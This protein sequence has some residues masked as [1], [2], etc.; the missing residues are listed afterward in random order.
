MRFIADLHIHSHYSRATSKHM[1]IVE[2]TKWS[3]MKGTNVLGTGD[4]THPRWFEEIQKKLVEADDAPGLFRL[5]PE[6]ESEIQKEVPESCRVPMRFMLTVEISTIYKKNDA[7]R[8]VHSCIFAP[9]FKAAAGLNKTLDAIGNIKSDGRPILGLDTKLL[10]QHALDNGCFFVPA[11]IWTPHFSVFGS[12]SGFDTLQECFEDLTPHI[13]AIETGLSSDP[14]MNWRIKELDGLAIISNSDAHSAAKLGREAN[15]FNTD[16]SYDAII[17]ALKDNDHDAFEST[18]EFYPE[19]GKYHLDGH[20]NCGVQWMPSETLKNSKL[21]STCGKKVTVGVMH[22]VQDL[23]DPERGEDY[24]PEKFRPYSSIIPLPEIIAEVEGVKTLSSKK[25]QTKHLDMLTKLG[26]EFHI[27]LDASLSD[28]QDKAGV[29]MA[30]A[31]K[32]MREGTIHID[33]GY[34]GE[35]GHIKIFEPDEKSKLANQESLF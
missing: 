3:Q 1:N 14:Q 11:H 7:V 17:T 16:M 4:F 5:K 18:I 19:E 27:L 31:I 15:V 34:D 23:A 20:R 29:L 25:V 8:K 32:R 13:Y 30:E 10:L 35:F 24:K 33:P 21:C 2:L 12:M 26:N 28:I 6:F 9:S 22:R